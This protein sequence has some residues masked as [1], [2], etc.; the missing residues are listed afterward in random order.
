MLQASQKNVAD[1]TASRDAL[2]ETHCWVERRD[3]SGEMLIVDDVSYFDISFN[4]ERNTGRDLAP[5]FQPQMG[6]SLT[7]ESWRALGVQYFPYS[8][9]VQDVYRPWAVNRSEQNLSKFVSSGV[10]FE[11]AQRAMSEFLND[12]GHPI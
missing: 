11:S 7:P 2:V 4:N 5:L 9:Q 3:S 10:P 1:A 8:Q 12:W 6:L